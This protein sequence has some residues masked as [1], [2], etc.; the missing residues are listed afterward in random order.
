MRRIST[1]AALVLAASVAATGTAR[2]VLA[3][4]GY[5]ICQSTAENPQA[6]EVASSG[7]YIVGGRATV[8]GQNLTPC[9]IAGPP[10][11]TGS[12]QWTSIENLTPAWNIGVN[13]VQLG[14][15]R[16]DR[17][18][19]DLGLGTVCDGSYHYYWA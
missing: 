8:E 12:F 5:A 15:G 19:N 9:I 18:N 4:G 1:L 10:Y 13:I 17:V 14:Y 7:G 3:A 11:A 2:P 6:G 16:C